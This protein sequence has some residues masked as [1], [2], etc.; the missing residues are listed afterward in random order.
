M[1][2]KILVVGMISGL[3]VEGEIERNEKKT[4]PGKRSKCIRERL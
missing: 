4:R 3:L 1:I 2:G